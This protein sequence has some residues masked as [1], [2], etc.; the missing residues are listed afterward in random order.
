MRLH[1]GAI[2]LI[3]LGVLSI[4][5]DLMPAEQLKALLAK[6]WPV[7]LILVGVA[8]MLRPRREA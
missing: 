2:I 1:L 3:L 7:V 6:W 8:A 4:N 5:L